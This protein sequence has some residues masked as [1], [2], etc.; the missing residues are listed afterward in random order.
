MKLIG[1][2]TLNGKG[3]LGK[4]R[5]QSGVQLF[6][7]SGKSIRTEFEGEYGS[8]GVR[9]MYSDIYIYT[10]IDVHIYISHMYICMCIYINTCIERYVY[11]FIYLYTHVKA[12]GLEQY[13]RQVQA[14]KCLEAL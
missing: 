5:F 6:L 11:T 9:Y 8:W 2:L 3:E 7:V 1:L 14:L 10:H 12:F 13:S 4:L